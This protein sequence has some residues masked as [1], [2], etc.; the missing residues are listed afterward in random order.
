[1]GSSDTN[2]K[3]LIID[4]H[5]VIFKI[6]ELKKLDDVAPC[7]FLE[8]LN[9]SCLEGY[10]EVKVVFDAAEKEN[11]VKTVGR[12]RCIYTGSGQKADEVILRE[13]ENTFGAVVYVVSADSAVQM[14]TISRGGLRMTPRELMKTI[15]SS[16]DFKKSPSSLKKEPTLYECLS[17]NERAKIDELYDELIRHQMKGKK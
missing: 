6:P 11:V 12:V 5:N 9:S 14:G 8:M 15:S 7:R 13:I 4:G 3:V 1:M 2:K 17:E 16:S 10:D